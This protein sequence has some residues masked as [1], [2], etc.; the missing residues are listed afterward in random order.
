MSETTAAERI[1]KLD[2]R[3]DAHRADTKST[4]T[5]IVQMM[6]RTE[7]AVAD[8]T[9]TLLHLNAEVG[10]ITQKIKAFGA[11]VARIDDRETE[12]FVE[13]LKR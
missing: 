10:V 9:E 4:I 8:A 6:A 13:S 5:D 1:A 12:W 3:I 11:S 7:R 2:A